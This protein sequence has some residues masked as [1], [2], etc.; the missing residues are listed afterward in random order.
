MSAATSDDR[1][2]SSALR[3]F[4]APAGRKTGIRFSARREYTKKPP[5]KPGGLHRA[6]PDGEKL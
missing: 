6:D 1:V 2:R 5:G 4:D 3:L